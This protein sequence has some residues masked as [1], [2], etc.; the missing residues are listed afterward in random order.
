MPILRVDAHF[1]V[2]EAVLKGYIK[3]TMSHGSKPPQDEQERISMENNLESWCERLLDMQFEDPIIRKRI[4]QLAAAFSI[5]LDKKVSF[6]LKVLEALLVTRLPEIPEF[7][8]YS[9]A[10]KELQTD[11]MHELLRLATKMPDHLLVS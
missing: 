5:T 10:V 4:L 9:D 11:C 1:T 2:V 8:A 3:S 6:M 7:P